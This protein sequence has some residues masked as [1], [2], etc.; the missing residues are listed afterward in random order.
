MSSTVGVSDTI[1][2]LDTVGAG[3]GD[4]VGTLDTFGPSVVAYHAILPWYSALLGYNKIHANGPKE[5]YQVN[6]FWEVPFYT[7]IC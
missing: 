3:A 1:G 4:T 2:A 5:L 6:T 7:H